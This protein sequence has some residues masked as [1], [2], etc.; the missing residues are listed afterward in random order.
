MPMVP[1]NCRLP[2]AAAGRRPPAARR[3]RGVYVISVCMMFEEVEFTPLHVVS[4]RTTDNSVIEIE[5]S[6]VVCTSKGMF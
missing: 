6:Y 3:A 1:I 2:M 4:K 5:Y